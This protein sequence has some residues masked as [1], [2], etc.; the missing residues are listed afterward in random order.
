MLDVCLVRWPSEDCGVC[1]AG[2]WSVCVWAQKVGVQQWNLL[3]TWTFTQVNT[4]IHMS[5]Y[6]RLEIFFP[7]CIPG[8]VSGSRLTGDAPRTP[9]QHAF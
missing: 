7:L 8:R 3:H 5:L 2:E 6:L 4:Y 9:M 1:G